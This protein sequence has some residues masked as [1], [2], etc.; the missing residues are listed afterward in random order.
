MATIPADPYDDWHEQLE[1]KRARV[2]ALG[3]LDP[4]LFNRRPENGKWSIGENLEH[5]SLSLGPYL[6]TIEEAA[7]EARRRG[8]TGTGP[9]KRG[10][11]VAWFIRSSEPPVKLKVRTFR[12]LV[13][14]ESLDRDRVV[15]QLLRLT[16][17]FGGVIDSMRGLDLGRVKLRSPILPLLKLDL[18]SAVDLNLAHDRRHL[19]IIDRIL[20]RDDFRV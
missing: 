6:T 1:R 13:P 20:E 18:A 16:G 10:W 12:T 19:W 3:E 5:L 17:D 8:R 7:E 14:A 11:F 4:D 15:E 2:R 9:W